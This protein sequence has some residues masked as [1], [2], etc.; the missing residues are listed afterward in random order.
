MYEEDNILEEIKERKAEKRYKWIVFIVIIGVAILARINYEGPNESLA[1]SFIRYFVP[2]V[3]ALFGMLEHGNEYLRH[4]PKKV[5]ES[6][7]NPLGGFVLGIVIAVMGLTVICGGALL[8]N[9]AINLILHLI[10]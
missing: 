1:R 4:H 5:E 3:F 6:T 8:V 7:H 10:A 2:G 9:G